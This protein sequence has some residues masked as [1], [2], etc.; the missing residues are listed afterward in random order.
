M[1]AAVIGLGATGARVARQLQSWP[2]IERLK[3]HDTSPLRV[4]EAIA[5]LGEG[6][7]GSGTVDEA[8]ESCDVAVLCFPGDPVPAARRALRAGSHVVSL[9]T[10]REAAAG[11]LDLGE[12]A[13]SARRHV[14]VGAGFS[15]G[16]S[17]LVVAHVAGRFE[18]LEAIDLA[19][20]G[21]GGMACR[22][23]RVGRTIAGGPAQP[24]GEPE[25]GTS[26]KAMLRSL[27][28]DPA[29]VLRWFPEPLGQLR[30]EGASGAEELL[31]ADFGQG[32]PSVALHRHLPAGEVVLALLPASLSSRK[33]ETDLGGL[34]AEVRGTTARGSEVVLAGAVDRPAVAAGTVAAVAAG[35]A[36]DGRLGGPWSGGVGMK[37]QRPEVF[38]SELAVRGVKIAEFLPGSTT[39]G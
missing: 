20:T 25:G 4:Q 38:L 39:D 9:S 1:R 6:S 7:S 36:V 11:L 22:R 21:S 12:M 8:L 19:V 23:E 13:A 29:A 33:P 15:P 24:G 30:C 37:V 17:E 31:L 3:L 35:W 18:R 34:A 28:P 27:V 10:T 5:S 26:L 16:L 32:S 2:S 14:V